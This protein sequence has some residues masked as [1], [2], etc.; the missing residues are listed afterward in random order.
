MF[1]PVKP[2]VIRILPYRFLTVNNSDRLYM[3]SKGALQISR[4]FL[5]LKVC[6]LYVLMCGFVVASLP[7]KPYRFKAVK[8]S[9]IQP[10]VCLKYLNLILVFF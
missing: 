1:F 4:T 3:H 6:V 9:A 10:G 5:A 7:E 8:S 2:T